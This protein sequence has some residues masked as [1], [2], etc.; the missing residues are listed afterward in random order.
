LKKL[1]PRPPH[2]PSGMD[3]ATDRGGSGSSGN[4]DAAGEK[5]HRRRGSQLDKLTI[6]A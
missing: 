5:P 6:A 3:Q 2:K 4:K 1:P